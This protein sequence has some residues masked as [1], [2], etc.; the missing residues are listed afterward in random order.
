[1]I[2]ILCFSL[3]GYLLFVLA[4]MALQRKLLYYPTHHGDDNGLA[5]WRHQGRQMGFVREIPAPAN[6]WL[7]VHG[8]AGQ[9]SD[10]VYA[11]P[12]FSG[13]DS[14]FILEYPGYG[15]RPGSPSR[16]AF[17]AAAKEAYLALRARFPQTPVCVAAESIGSG[18]AA[19]LATLPDPPD[20]LVLV[21]PFD[22]LSKVAAHHF[23]YLPARLLLWD[24]WDNVKALQGYRGRLEVFGAR[25]DDIIPISH[26]RALAQ[27]V[28][29]ARFHEIEGGHNDWAH[30]GRVAIRN[31]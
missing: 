30:P 14:V 11:L 20:K 16:K 7:F 29:G 1:M 9:A 21:S 31:P 22:V 13:R 4:Y 23:P 2:R 28:P 25:D 6:V 19:A 10:R 26:S 3:V 17:D 15:G 12:S 24:D 18:P 5:Q 27:S 8:N